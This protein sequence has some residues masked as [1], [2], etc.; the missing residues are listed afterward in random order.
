MLPLRPCLPWGL[1]GADLQWITVKQSF[2][3][4][5]EQLSR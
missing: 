4:E 2:L 3:T 5:V 1:Q